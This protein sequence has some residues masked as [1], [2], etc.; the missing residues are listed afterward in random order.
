MSSSPE[1]GGAHIKVLG[2]EM[3]IIFS[4]VTSDVY[5]E[6]SVGLYSLKTDCEVGDH[7]SYELTAVTQK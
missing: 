2:F 1:G 5:C 6:V 7:L 3:R 4:Q